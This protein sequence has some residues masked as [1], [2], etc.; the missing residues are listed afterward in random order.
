MKPLKNMLTLLSFFLLLTLLGCTTNTPGDQ[1]DQSDQG[2][3]SEN[4]EVNNDPWSQV[5]TGETVPFDNDLEAWGGPEADNT[6]TTQ[7]ERDE[8]ENLDT[9]DPEELN[10]ETENPDE[11]E[12]NNP[13]ETQEA[14]P[15]PTNPEESTEPNTGETSQ[16][17][18][19]YS[20]EALK[21]TTLRWTDLRLE[22]TL[23]ENAAY[24]RYRISYLSNDLRIS[25]ILNIPVGDGPFP[26]AIL[27]HGYIDPAVYTVWRGL[28]REQDA[29]ARNG[30]AVLHTDYRNHGLSDDDPTL[31]ENYVFR[32]FF[33]TQDSLNAV[34]ALQERN[35]PRLDTEAV[36][37]LWHSMGWWVSMHAMIARPD[38][39]DAVALYAPVHSNERY[40]FQRRRAEDLTQ[41]E[42]QQRTDQLGDLSDPDN[43]S[44]YSAHPA[45]PQRADQYNTPIKIYHWTNDQ[46]TPY[47]RSTTTRTALSD[48]G[49]NVELITYQWEQHEFTTRR[50]NFITNV[51]DF[52]NSSL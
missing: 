29:L 24:T 36:W 12:N 30:I 3:Q 44:A 11:T 7:P 17:P 51:I 42:R 34:L 20:L 25:G 2:D 1:N 5:A 4:Q 27:N 13:D 31:E 8:A 41:Q 43:F 6:E 19:P 23:A 49:A 21:Q 33:Y 16:N 47:E 52:F 15:E 32:N 48:A 50:N 37:M 40:N 14:G 46:S 45:F 38:L 10:P 22:T 28:K 26:V 9:T 39:V 18:L 35:D